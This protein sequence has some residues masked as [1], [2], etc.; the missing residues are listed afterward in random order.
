[1]TKTF[2]L[3]IQI[4]AFNI[5]KI[6][7]VY[8]KAQV[9][10][11]MQ[12]GLLEPNITATRSS[13]WFIQDIQDSKN[14]CLKQLQSFNAEAI[15]RP[16]TAQ[17]VDCWYCLMCC[18]RPELHHNVALLCLAATLTDI[19]INNKHFNVRCHSLLS[20]YWILDGSLLSVLIKII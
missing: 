16:K 3:Y 4:Q 1:M 14:R 13:M 7:T 10:I 6:H 8:Q 12:I 18:C 5:Q 20:L 2:P 9:G 11:F 17:D 15:L 19:Y